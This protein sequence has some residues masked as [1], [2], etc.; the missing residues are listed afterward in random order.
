MRDPNNQLLKKVWELRALLKHEDSKYSGNEEVKVQVKGKSLSGI[1]LFSYLSH[2]KAFVASQ[3]PIKPESP[4]ISDVRK[5]LQAVLAN[6]PP[7]KIHK[8][9][10]VIQVLEINA[11]SPRD[12]SLISQELSRLTSTCIELLENLPEHLQQN[13]YEEVLASIF[14]VNNFPNLRL[15][16]GAHL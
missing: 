15:I 5:A 1:L 6:A 3:Q 4:H 13:D 14:Q 11:V 16:F 12:F 7:L 9:S 8:G 10:S 2:F